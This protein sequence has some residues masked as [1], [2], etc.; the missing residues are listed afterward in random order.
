MKT[1]TGTFKKGWKIGE[2]VHMDFELRASTT[3]DIFA[4]EAMADAS[5]PLTFDGALICVQLVRVGTYTGPVTLDMLGS[6]KP[7][8]F[9]TL[10]QK[11]V[12]VDQGED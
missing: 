6:L 10:R 3:A 12:E 1:V 5:K 4:A 2:T 8:D 11:L 9:S 7:A